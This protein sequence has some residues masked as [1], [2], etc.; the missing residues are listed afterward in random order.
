[1]VVDAVVKAT[2]VLVPV[3]TVKVVVVSK[4]RWLLQKGYA[5]AVVLEARSSL[6]RHT[7]D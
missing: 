5:S 4:E 3:T 7:P 2:A 1:M 6:N